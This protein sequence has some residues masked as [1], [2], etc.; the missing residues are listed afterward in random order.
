MLVPLLVRGRALG[1]IGFGSAGSGRRYERSDLALAEEVARR[2]AQAIENAQAYRDAE[3]A[4]AEA[5]AANRAKDEFLAT[6]SHELRTPLN[7]ILGWAQV[8]RVGQNDPT[9]VQQAL[10]TIERNARRQAQLIDDLL[11]LSRIAAGKLRLEL[12]PVDLT[13]VIAAAVETVRPAADVKTIGI[14]LNLEAGPGAVMGDSDRLQ[15]VFTNL[16]ANAVKFTPNGGRVEVRLERAG[17]R[18]RVTVS[19]TGQGIAPELLPVIFERFR[20][21]DSSMTRAHGGLG[22]GLAIVR[23]LV[24]LHGGAVEA[25]SPGLGQGA[26]FTV[27]LPPMLVR[28]EAPKRAANAPVAVPCDGIHVLVVDDEPDGRQV[29]AAFLEASGATVTAVGSAREALAALDRERPHVIVTD[30]A[31]PEQDGFAFLRAVRSRPADRG[32]RIPLVALTAHAEWTTRGRALQSGFETHLTKP[33]EA[34][35]LAAIVARVAGR[36]S[37]PPPTA[38]SPSG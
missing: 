38:R 19:D 34:V 10:S 18:V 4:R 22:L 12:I 17:S 16:L 7:A 37:A 20:Q 27:T 30:L 25:A 11:D 15:Q 32:G 33:V 28:V 21:V 14:G 24:E 13:A 8:L 6:L 9:Q 5:E 31:M 3:A 36:T 29:L 2:A 23:H 1:A 35:E 26:T